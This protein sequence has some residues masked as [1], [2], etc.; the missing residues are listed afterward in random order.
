MHCSTLVCVRV[1]VGEVSGDEAESEAPAV[2]MDF[3]IVAALA[4]GRLTCPYIVLP[5]PYAGVHL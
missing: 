1:L 3:L 2:S 4:V 5:N